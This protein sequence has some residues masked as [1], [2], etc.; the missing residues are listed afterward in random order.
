MMG[1][2]EGRHRTCAQLE[3]QILKTLNRPSSSREI[4]RAITNCNGATRTIT[5][6]FNNLLKSGK[7]RRFGARYSFD[8]GHEVLYVM[9]DL[10]E[11]IL[12]R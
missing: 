9:V 2:G 6:A 3:A 1:T 11:C 8:Y 5:Q 12:S 4:F 7:V 10:S